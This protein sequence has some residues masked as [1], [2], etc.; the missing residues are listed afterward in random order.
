MRNARI[1]L[2]MSVVS[3]RVLMMATQLQGMVDAADAGADLT[4]KLFHCTKMGADGRIVLAG[5]GERVYGII[6]EEAEE[7][8]PVT[9]MLDGIA[10][11]KAGAAI[12]AG[13]RV[14]SDGNGQAITQA[15]GGI[16]FGIARTAASAAGALVEVTLG[17]GS[18]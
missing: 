10:K 7:D 14:Q 15:G 5:N 11:V 6:Q 18:P 9:V 12:V 13:A 1:P 3:S 8:Q 17:L 4:G 2:L 16:A